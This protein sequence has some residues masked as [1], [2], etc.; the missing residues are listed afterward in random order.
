MSDNIHPNPGPVFPCS[1]CGGN[2]T[3]RGKS[4]QCC[5]CFKCVHLKCSL[6]SFCRL[7][8]L[9]SSLCCFFSIPHTYQHCNFLLGLLKLVYLNCAT[10]PIW[11]PLLMQHSHTT[12]V[13]KT[14]IH[15]LP[16]S[17]LLPLYPH[18]PLKFLAVF[19]YLCFLFHPDWV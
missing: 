5:T 9:G 1:L 2:V 8:T 19:L 16:T 6:F 14:P 10:W 18:H 7:K 17:Y 11:P 12:L 3:W 13:F 15:L 4:A